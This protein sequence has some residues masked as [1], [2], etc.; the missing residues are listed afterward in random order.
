MRR[1]RWRDRVVL[2]LALAVTGTMLSCPARKL[3]KLRDG[4]SGKTPAPPFR[5]VYL[6]YVPPVADDACGIVV[7]PGEA[8]IWA[9]P[10]KPHKVMWKVIDKDS[11]HKWVITKKGSQAVD[12]FPTPA[13]KRIPCGPSDSFNSGPPVNTK[14][15]LNTWDYGI[16]VFRCGSDGVP[17][18]LLCEVDPK[19]H[20]RG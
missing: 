8:W 13:K 2:L 15:G 1:G 10:K 5:W 14:P 6:E 18:E 3:P 9:P 17:D 12:H 16:Q 4:V 19:L 20:I 11:D 7:T